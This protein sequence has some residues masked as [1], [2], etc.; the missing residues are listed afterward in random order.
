MKFFLSSK[1]LSHSISGKESNLKRVRKSHNPRNKGINLFIKK[2]RLSKKG[3][4]LVR[5]N[6][7]E[8]EQ[9]IFKPV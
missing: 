4:D 2:F 1:G 8:E 3:R 6:L 5:Q 7:S 9:E